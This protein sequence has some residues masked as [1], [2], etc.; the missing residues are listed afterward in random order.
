MQIISVDLDYFYPNNNS[1]F[2]YCVEENFHLQDCKKI[3]FNK[4]K[5]IKKLLK[6]KKIILLNTHDELI[7]Y[8]NFKDEV[9]NYDFHHDV[10]YDKEDFN[11]L[12]HF[13]YLDT[14]TRESCWAGYAI[15]FLK[16]DYNWISDTDSYIENITKKVNFK[17]NLTFEVK[18]D[19]IYLI[20]SLNYINKNQFKFLWRCL[21]E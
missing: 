8:I 13:K 3:D 15:K 21:F 19:T 14:E 11:L 10:I 2:D 18:T 9:I 17:I 20:K 1:I 7:N 12:N 16:I 6:N 5:E 4:I